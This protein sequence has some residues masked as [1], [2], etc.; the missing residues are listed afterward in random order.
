MA[1]LW[2]DGFEA[3]DYASQYVL[4]STWAVPNTGTRF[5]YGRYLQNLG[6]SRNAQKNITPAAEMFFGAAHQ[7]AYN[8]SSC[9]QFYGDSG[10]LVHIRITFNVRN[11]IDVWR[12]PGT[13]LLASSPDNVWAYGAWNYFEVRVKVA[14][15]GGI[16]QVRLNGSSTNVIDFT[17]DT[18]NGG[19]STN[20]DSFML[21][22]LGAGSP[23]SNW[24]DLYICDATGTANNTFL[25]EVK[26]Q[27][28]FPTG[29]GATTGL[30]PSAGANWAAVDDA[31]PS[32]SDF[33][34]S[35]TASAKDTYA[36]TD[37]TAGTTAVKGVRNTA[38]WRKTETSLATMRHVTRVGST[39]YAG[40]SVTLTASS[41]PHSDYLNVSPAT[42]SAWTVSEVNGMEIGADVA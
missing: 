20:I 13:T 17:G 16:V 18:R 41:V 5:G 15:S 23:T 2:C 38:Y 4:S 12:G 28:L 24:D 39:D 25:G 9:V 32:S 35:S 30:A 34:S 8:D 29:A 10:T 3:Q 21:A 33:V 31:P 37:L 7:T 11:G 19:T 27:T 6:N 40:T 22:T 26:V 1:L 14:D 42:S 36:I